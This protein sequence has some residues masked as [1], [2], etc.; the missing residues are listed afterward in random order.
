V[1]PIPARP[2]MDG[3]AFALV[4]NLDATGGQTRLDLGAGEAVGDGII[5]GVDVDVIVEAD[6][7]DSPHTVFVRLIR[8]RLER[9]AVDLLEQLPA[10]DA[11]PAQGLLLIELGHELAERGVD[12]AEAIEDPAP[13]PAD[14]PALDDQ[15]GLL[16]LR[17]GQ[18]CQL[19]AVWGRA[20]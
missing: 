2:Y 5:V 17:F 12:V 7:A 8:Q 20:V 19:Q 9:W 14:E 18:S 16:D 13:E 11:E 10:G 4:E 1:L 6:P 3:D 15:D